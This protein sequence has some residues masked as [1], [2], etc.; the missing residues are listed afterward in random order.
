MTRISQLKR[1]R[2]E[3]RGKEAGVFS[4]DDVERRAREIAGISGRKEVTPED[5]ERARAELLETDL[6]ATTTEDAES[7]QSLSRDPSDPPAI[8]GK[9]TPE[10]VE[11]DEKQAL[12]RLALEGVEE[13]QHDQMSR[14]RNPQADEN[15]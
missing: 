12:E 11:I 10:Y 6:P 2:V 5:R 1:G 7:T 4:P 14:A 3:E 15:R 9:Q 13:A 8:R